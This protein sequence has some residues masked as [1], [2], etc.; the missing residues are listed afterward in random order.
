M[1]DRIMHNVKNSARHDILSSLARVEGM[2]H[3]AGK[4]SNGYMLPE[5]LP[6]LGEAAKA[7]IR[8][9]RKELSNPLPLRQSKEQQEL[10]GKVNEMYHEWTDREARPWGWKE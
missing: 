3:G 1:A 8:E 7:M 5:E 9:S 6:H 10:S 2:G 4:Y